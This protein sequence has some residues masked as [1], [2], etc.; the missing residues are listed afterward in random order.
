[1]ITR[2]LKIGI[3]FQIFHSCAYTQV[4][5]TPTDRAANQSCIKKNVVE[6]AV[7]ERFE[8]ILSVKVL[9]V[10]AECPMGLNVSQAKFQKVL[11]AINSHRRDLISSSHMS[12]NLNGKSHVA[13]REISDEHLL[14]NVYSFAFPWYRLFEVDFS[15]DS[16]IQDHELKIDV[17]GIKTTLVWRKK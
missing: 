7:Y 8:K 5:F 6:K 11:L 3:L 2:I 13:I 17:S 14:R 15:L 16:E 10:S 1:M 4:P 9:P 12:L